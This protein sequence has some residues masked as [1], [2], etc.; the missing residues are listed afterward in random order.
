MMTQANQAVGRFGGRTMRGWF[1]ARARGRRFGATPKRSGAWGVGR[2]HP[3]ARQ[4]LGGGTE[5][6]AFGK[7]PGRSWPVVPV[8]GRT[9]SYAVVRGRTRWYAAVQGRLWPFAAAIPMA[10]KGYK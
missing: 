4:R 1:P 9:W 2:S 5:S 8:H 10:G 7:V 3:Q 6:L